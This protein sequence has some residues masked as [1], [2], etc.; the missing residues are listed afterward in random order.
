MTILSEC[1][2]KRKP[3][4]LMIDLSKNQYFRLNITVFAAARIQD[5]LLYS[6]H[7]SVHR[8]FFNN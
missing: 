5:F 8:R 3:L 1:K 2:R 4:S 7:K 6:N